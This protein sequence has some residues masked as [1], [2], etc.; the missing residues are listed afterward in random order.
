MAD[1]GVA[2]P[3]IWRQELGDLDVTVPVTKGTRGKDVEIKIQKRFL[4]VGLKGKEPILAGELPNDIKVEDS[5][6]TIGMF[7]SSLVAVYKL[8]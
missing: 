8:S 4:S 1:H 7:C 3:Y 5:T 2:L 6:W